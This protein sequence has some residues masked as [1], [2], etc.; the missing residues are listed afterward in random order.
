MR[1]FEKESKAERVLPERERDRLRR[2]LTAARREAD[3]LLS[4][5]LMDEIDGKAFKRKNGELQAR[6]AH[7]QLS[8]D[9][10]DKDDAE[11]HGLALRAFELF[12]GG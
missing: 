12:A 10:S 9:V 3:T 6:I 11:N 5:R 1:V 8:V 7:L 2:E 4:M